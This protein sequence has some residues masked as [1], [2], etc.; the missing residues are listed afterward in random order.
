MYT[1]VVPARDFKCIEQYLRKGR[2]S[3][4]TIELL[5]RKYE[6]GDDN[7]VITAEIL[8]KKQ[9]VKY[10]I[11]NGECSS[12]IELR[13]PVCAFSTFGVTVAFDRDKSYD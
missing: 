8:E 10:T 12:T 3:P 13:S 11:S 9:A 2:I 7:Y 4:E 6:I 1:I 5:G